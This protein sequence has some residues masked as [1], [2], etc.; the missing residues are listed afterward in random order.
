MAANPRFV[1]LL[2]AV[3]G[4]GCPQPTPEPRQADRSSGISAGAGEMAAPGGHRII[5]GSVS[6]SGA[7]G[8]LQGDSHQLSHGGLH[9]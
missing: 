6:A 1:V 2:L 3:A 8:S 7:I 9:P 4:A 5:G